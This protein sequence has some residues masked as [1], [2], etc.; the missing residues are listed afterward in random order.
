M[1]LDQFMVRLGYCDTFKLERNKLYLQTLLY[2]P[3]VG[4]GEKCSIRIHA[5][6]DRNSTT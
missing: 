2:I 3:F 6:M 5:S 4:S 1:L